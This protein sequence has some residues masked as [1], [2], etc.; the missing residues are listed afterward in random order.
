[1]K[2]VRNGGNHKNAMAQCKKSTEKPL[3][4]RTKGF[5]LLKN[6]VET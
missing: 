1:M 2:T 5:S 4:G 6:R 3:L